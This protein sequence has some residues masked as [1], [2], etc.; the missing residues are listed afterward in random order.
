M[1]LFGVCSQANERAIEK[2]KIERCSVARYFILAHGQKPHMSAAL[3]EQYATIVLIQFIDSPGINDEF[4][5]KPVAL[6][7]DDCSL[8]PR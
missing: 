7:I 2:Q 4:A 6:R 5:L 3:L 8:N 1:A